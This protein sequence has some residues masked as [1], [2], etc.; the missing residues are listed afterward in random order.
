MEFSA[1]V[2]KAQA[3]NMMSH[4]YGQSQNNDMLNATNNFTFSYLNHI[5]DAYGDQAGIGG[6]ERN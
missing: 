5:S 1:L 6:K 3:K 4:F 2:A